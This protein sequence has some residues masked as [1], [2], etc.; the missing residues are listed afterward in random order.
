MHI[1][2][3]KDYVDNGEVIGRKD[4]LKHVPQS[5]GVDLIFRKVARRYRPTSFADFLSSNNPPAVPVPTEW[6]TQ[7]AGMYTQACILK[8]DANGLT[9]FRT[10]PPDCPPSIAARWKSMTDGAQPVQLSQQEAST[11]IAARKNMNGDGR[12]KVRTHVNGKSVTID[13]VEQGWRI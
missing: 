10:P 1:Q 8:R 9:Y 7:P 12:A 2:F 11:I 4:D 5:V 3:L 13:P 6:G